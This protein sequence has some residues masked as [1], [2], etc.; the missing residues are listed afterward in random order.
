MLGVDVDRPA[1]P[2]PE[3]GQAWELAAALL[4]IGLPLLLVLA[5]VVRFLRGSWNP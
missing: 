1:L 5:L 4:L 2:Q 3:D